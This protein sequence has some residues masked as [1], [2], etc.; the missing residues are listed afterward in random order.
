MSCA[1]FVKHVLQKR[2]AVWRLAGDIRG[3]G[4]AILLRL[5]DALGW[6]ED[7]S[8]GNGAVSR[9][10]VYLPISSLEPNLNSASRGTKYRLAP[11]WDRLLTCVSATTTYSETTL[12]KYSTT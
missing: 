10:G 1:R 3:E 7:V 4:A 6:Q 9:Y 5:W 8:L 12:F 11:S 2:R